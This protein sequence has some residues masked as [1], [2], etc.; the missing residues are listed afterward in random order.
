MQPGGSE[1]EGSNVR[2]A[3]W[4]AIA[5]IAGTALAATCAGCASEEV[6]A[7]KLGSPVRDER[8]EP[9]ALSVAPAPDEAAPAKGRSYAVVIGISEYADKRIPALRFAAKD[10]ESVFTFLVDEAGLAYPPA[11][12]RLLLDG[13]ATR[14]EIQAAIRWLNGVAQPLDT[15]LVYYAGHGTVD[16]APDGS[17]R[18]NYL[19][20]SDARA[21]EREGGLA[22]DTATGLALAALQKDL[23]VNKA[24][25]LLLVLDA[26]FSGGTS[27]SLTPIVLDKRQQKSSEAEFEGLAEASEARAVLTATLPNQPALE[28]DRLGHGL[29]T[30]YLLEGFNAD[31]DRNGEVTLDEVYAYVYGHV[32]DEARALKQAQTPLL[33]Q[34]QKGKFVLRALP[35]TRFRVGLTVR[36]RPDARALEARAGVPAQPEVVRSARECS[37]EVDAWNPPVPLSTSLLRFAVT[38]AGARS[39]RLLPDGE[40]ALA[41]PVTVAEGRPAA[42]PSEEE[43]GAPVAPVPADERDADVVYV[44]VA[45]ETALE[46]AA[47]DRVERAAREAAARFPPANLA[48]VVAGV[49]EAE[50]A[51][52]HAE[53]RY[54]FA[55]H[56]RGAQPAIETGRPAAPT[57]EGSKPR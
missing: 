30:Y 29:F 26:C 2:G 4:A 42:W 38:A 16:V 57:G 24:S 36:Y 1:E 20:P 46:L 43:T 5:M 34:S 47:I 53:L 11:D 49:F 14:A 31:A 22:L 10:A 33:K 50:P 44:L 32:S 6:G 15:V 25:R 7:R 39:A 45:S 28:I 37:A 41:P 51:L 48:R 21:L 40:N 9:L 19:V 35:R 12:V 18:G 56:G 54:V 8:A 17:V 13:H 3:P 27:R 55:R 52:K 23:Q